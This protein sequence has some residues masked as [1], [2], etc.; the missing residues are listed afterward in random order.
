MAFALVALPV[1]TAQAADRAA[2][3]P[4]W[5][6][7]TLTG[8]WGGARAALRDK[9][10]D[11]T[12]VYI[13]ETFAVL[14]G[15]L[16]RRGSDEGRFEFT[17]EADLE[18]LIGW[19]GATTHI[20]AYQ[21]H[22]GGR[23]A[24]DNTGSISD[25][26]NIDAVTTT[27]LFTAWFQQ[28]ALNDRVSLRAGQ[29]AA[30]DEFLNSQTASGLIDGT[31]GWADI[32]AANLLSG[33]PAYPLATP[34]ARL[35]VKPSDALT[36]QAAVFSGDPAGKGCTD[37]PQKCNR[38]GTT[39]SF[40][41]GAL[42]MGE[43]Q[44]A[45]NQGKDAA[46]L[47]GVY[48]LG[49]WYAT[50]NYNDRHFGIGASGAQVSLGAD[51]SATPLTHRGNGGLYGVADQMVWRGNESS[52]NL[53]LRGGFA[54]SDRNLVSYYIDA[55]AGLKGPLPGRQNDTLTFG[56][57]YARISKDVAAADRDT[58]PAAIVR[59]YEAVFELSYA[60]QIAPWWTVQPDVQYIV[61]PNGG[62]NPNDPAA[63][64]QNAFV[65]GVR[66]SIKF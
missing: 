27:R 26:S 7:A 55:G 9:G 14:S 64:L 34:G 66:S 13:G 25:P 45:V 54:P 44:Y 48:K 29:L 56:F 16:A 6:Q 23:T 63:R 38:T 24:S 3:K 42:W 37:I 22:N 1:A 50:A 41:G 65:A 40:S 52:L 33:G 10:L 47:P 39:F 59:D 51:P 36:L 12:L 17:S 8:D 60:A 19:R 4:V 21:I 28:S 46:G 53:F 2:P 43:A 49:A 32:M 31:F 58:L 18:K 35:A 30:D 20:T 57:A 15:G 11:L 61:H 5:E 62:Q